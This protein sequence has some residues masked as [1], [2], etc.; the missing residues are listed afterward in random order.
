MLPGPVDVLNS[1]GTLDVLGLCF[2]CAGVALGYDVLFGFTGLLSFGQVLYF[3]IGASR[4]RLALR[5]GTGRCCRGGRVTLA[6]G[7]V[8]ALVLGAISLRGNGIAFTMVTLAFAQVGYYLIEDNPAKLTGGDTGLVMSAARLPAALVGVASTRDLYWLALVFL[9]RRARGRLAGH[10]VVD[11]PGV[12]RD[13]GERAAGGS[14]RLPPVPFKLASFGASSMIATGGRNGL[15]A[16]RGDRL[17]GT[18]SPRPR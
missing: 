6:A 10:R 1:A 5:Y 11:R 2:V 12:A 7:I 17:P 16:A 3:A 9:V 8:V 18:R 13:Q 15:P 4:P 14:A